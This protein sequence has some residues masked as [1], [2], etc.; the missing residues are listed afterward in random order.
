MDLYQFYSKPST[1]LGAKEKKYLPWVAFEQATKGKKLDARQLAV[2]A[3]DP[4]YAYSYAREIIQGS[5]PQGEAAIANSPRYAYNYANYIVQ[6]RW[7]KGEAAIASDSSY[8]YLYAL[9]VIQG[10]W[11]EGEAAIASNP[12]YAYRYAILNSLS[13]KS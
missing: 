8:A 2:I 1:L 6:N 4:K 9:Y 12:Y 7:P 11:P 13:K 5:W 10:R 3:S